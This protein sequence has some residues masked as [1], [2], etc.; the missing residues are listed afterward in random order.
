MKTLFYMVLF[1]FSFTYLRAVDAGSVT[2]DIEKQFNQTLPMVL[3]EKPLKKELES[4]RDDT[5]ALKVHVKGFKIIGNTL[6]STK[7]LQRHLKPH[8]DK[9]L[10]FQQ[11]QNIATSIGEFYKQNGYSARA[12]LPPQEINNGIVTISVL[13][14][15]LSDVKMN[16]EGSKRVDKTYVKNVI[17]NIHPIGK[18]IE[19]KKLEKALMLISDIPGITFQSS[20]AAGKE[21]GDTE[22]KVTILDG[23]LIDGSI[24]TSN[25]GS[26]STGPEQIAIAMNVNSPFKSA[27]KLSSNIMKTEGVTYGKLAYEF[28]LGYSGLRLGFSGSAMQYNVIEGSSSDG[29]SS[30]LSFYAYYPIVRSRIFNLNFHANYDDKSFLNNTEGNTISDKSDKVFSGG[31]S[32]SYFD[33]YGM[34]QFGMTL[35]MGKIDLSKVQ[36]DY[37][38]DKDTV[39][40]NGYFTK[41]TFNGSRYFNLTD[42]TS[43]KISAT[44]Q[45][46]SKNLDS[47]EKLSLGGAYAVRAFTSSE[48]SG[49]EG[50]IINAE[51]S[52]RFK[53]HYKVSLFYDMGRVK[54]NK[55]LYE[56]WDVANNAD[57]TYL[58]KGIGASLGYNYG[59]FALNGTLAWRLGENPNATEDGM[60]SDGTKK[61]PRLW[62]LAS[63]GF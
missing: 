27:D 2:R 29:K 45:L 18:K 11:I 8:R 14:G 37:D 63:Y 56:N 53:K 12:F 22:V 17:E 24:S 25:T 58:L 54:Q 49:D 35:F 10:T 61:D 13:E 6:I 42:S 7:K 33:S 4:T 51:I 5:A 47:S 40:T 38:F 15:K 34:V 23:K 57:N 36:T 44:A 46:A 26:K 32:G 55:K 20:K 9:K 31:L 39:Q 19:T 1:F 62:I 48:G 52:Q 30:T 21:A 28:P 50:Y 43:V 59:S 60:D 16:T 3:P 41:M